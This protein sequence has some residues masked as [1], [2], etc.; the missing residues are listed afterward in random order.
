MARD[1]KLIFGLGTGRCGSTSLANLLGLDHEGDPKLPWAFSQYA[2]DNKLGYLLF[3]E[4]RGDVGMYYLPY[5]EA[6]LRIFPKAKFVCL[7]RDRDETVE[8]FKK[9][10]GRRNH[11]LVHNGNGWEL[12]LNW[13]DKYPKYDLL[14][15]DEAIGRY[16]DEYY[17]EAERLQSEHPSRFE[18]FP[19]ET[20]NSK[21]GQDSI[22]D[23]IGERMEY[24]FTRYNQSD[25]T[26]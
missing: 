5:V 18:I 22:F 17:T 7:K 10:I 20:L 15:R 4:K 1:N 12:D 2:L 26:R 24:D 11:W 23:F 6:I 9:K 3:L 8:S 13:D 16:W 19:I 14:N 25:V 21:K